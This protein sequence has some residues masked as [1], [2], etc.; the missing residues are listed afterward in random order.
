MYRVLLADSSCFDVFR[1][2]AALRSPCSQGSPESKVNFPRSL[3]LATASRRGGRA[4]LCYVMK[5]SGQ[6]TEATLSFS[7]ITIFPPDGMGGSGRKAGSP[8]LIGPE[9]SQPAI[10][11]RAGEPQGQAQVTPS[12]AGLSE[13]LHC[14]LPGVRG[15]ARC[16]PLWEVYQPLLIVLRGA[17][18]RLFRDTR[19]HPCGI[20]RGCCRNLREE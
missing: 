9:A 10:P 8:L 19:G 1:G 14:A 3:R 16:G 17:K 15:P 12:A 11:W 7:G 13:P 2:E 20:L 18:C 5:T 4:T 6:S